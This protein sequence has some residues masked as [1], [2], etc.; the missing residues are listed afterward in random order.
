MNTFD[1]LESFNIPRDRRLAPE[2]EA[3]GTLQSVAEWIGGGWRWIN[4]KDPTD[5]KLSRRRGWGMI[6][7]GVITTGAL[8]SA[9]G[10]NTDSTPVVAQNPTTVEAP[11]CNFST[12][13]DPTATMPYE[14]RNGDGTNAILFKIPGVNADQCKDSAY[15]VVTQLNAGSGIDLDTPQFGDTII[16]PASAEFVNG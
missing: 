8:L 2:R 16:L 7:L 1:S 4:H 13:T 5:V 3:S 15:D 6:S 9:H 14:I 11:H 10:C 12:D